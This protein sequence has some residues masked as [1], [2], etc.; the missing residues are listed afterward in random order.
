MIPDNIEII[1]RK[2]IIIFLIMLG[3]G[4]FYTAAPQVLNGRFS[5]SIYS[6][7]RADTA[8]ASKL[9]LRTYQMG[10]LNFGKDNTWLRSN[11]NLETD[12]V[13]KL[14]SDPRFRVYNLYLDVRNLWEL[15]SLKL[16]RQ[17]LY[18][19]IG[20]GVFDGATV[21]INYTDYKFQ[22]YYG[23][24]TPVYQKFDI[25]DNWNDNFILGSQ[26]SVY[27]LTDW[28]FSAKYIKKNFE[29]RAYTALRFDENLNP[30][31]MLIANKSNQ[32]EFLSGEISYQK[33]KLI[34]V[35]ARYD[36]D[37]N[38]ESTSLGEVYARYEGIEN[39]GF[40]L[41]YNYR[42]PRIRY[43]SIFSVF[44][45]GNTWE[46]EGGADY[47]FTNS[48]TVTG[49]FANVAFKG[50]TSQRATLGLSTPWGS[51]TGRKNFGFAGE[52]DA[53]SLFTAYSF[54]EGL[55][56]PSAGLSF[57]RYKLS[58]DDPLNNLVTFL[59][60]TNYRPSRMLSLDFQ[61]QFISNKIYKNDW[62]LF[63]RL[64]YWF[65]LIFN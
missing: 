49:K 12:I 37:L 26:I 36:Y 45:Y 24:N 59:A 20:G 52:M 17:P 56:T 46:V 9:H 15:V 18:N 60:G 63:L 65:N 42:E 53:I 6:F 50:E 11:F 22:V 28:Q 13:N 30:I 21:E 51:I 38:F 25:V 10:T 3:S 61:G 23:G 16:G 54:A 39:L 14:T 29:S 7:E 34:S 55:I 33:D 1:M 62:R 27:A 8:G 47:R 19:S 48:F 44:D 58:D 41:Y 2:I 32:Y 43:N 4:I 64:N 40:N 35:N 5:S 31:N 57:T